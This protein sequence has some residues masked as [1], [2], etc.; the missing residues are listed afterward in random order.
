[1]NKIL[2]NKWTML[3]IVAGMFVFFLTGYALWLAGLHKAGVV[4]MMTYVIP[5]F[6]WA[7]GV[8]FTQMLE[9]I[10]EEW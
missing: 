5:L 4:L 10:R 9:F 1:M 7:V 3:F 6:L 8:L 2:F